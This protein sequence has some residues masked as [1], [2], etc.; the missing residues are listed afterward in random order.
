MVTEKNPPGTAPADRR[1][2]SQEWSETLSAKIVAEIKRRRDALGLRAQDVADRAAELGIYLPRGVIARLE[3]GERKQLTVA[4]LFAFAAVLDV[5][6]ILFI[7]PVDSARAEQ[8]IAPS[9]DY[10]PAPTDDA[11]P[12]LPGHPV[13]V[14][15]VFN[16]FTG[17]GAPLPIT[18]AWEFRMDSPKWFNEMKRH[19]DAL[20]FRRQ[21]DEA[22]RQLM[23][24]LGQVQQL[25][26]QEHQTH[27]DSEAEFLRHQIK[28]GESELEVRF[29]NLIDNRKLM[30][31]KG[32]VL[33][34][35]DLQLATR[36]ALPPEKRGPWGIDASVME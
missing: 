26:R 25:R 14:D 13:D 34:Y 1:A 19:T 36:A 35:L 2:A 4:E 10:R 11:L 29:A 18:G 21:H 24:R 20:A 5:P 33:P 16:W 32:F 12:V 27:D 28:Q 17:G 30:Q 3:S 23:I 15:D 22:Q 9:G 8:Q 31:E 7:A 6:P